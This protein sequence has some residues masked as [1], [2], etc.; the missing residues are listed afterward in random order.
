MHQLNGLLHSLGGIQRRR[1]PPALE[2]RDFGQRG[3]AVAEP[4]RNQRTSLKISPLVV[5][6]S[7]ELG[8][9]SP[10]LALASAKD[11]VACQVPLERTFQLQR[12]LRHVG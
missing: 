2:A 1:E 5:A 8:S 6:P 3:S 9:P 12:V 10:T 11:G 4:D 7:F